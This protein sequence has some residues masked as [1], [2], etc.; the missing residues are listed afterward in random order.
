[1]TRLGTARTLADG[2]LGVAALVAALAVASV[3]LVPRLAPG[4]DEIPTVP[5]VSVSLAEDAAE[6]AAEG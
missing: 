3:A 2:R 4:E 1:V 5:A 6:D